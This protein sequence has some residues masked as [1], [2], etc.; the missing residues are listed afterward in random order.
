MMDAEEKALLVK[1]QEAMDHQL[2]LIKLARN[3]IK[4]Q[5]DVLEKL[6][7]RLDKLE[8]RVRIGF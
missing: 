6:M 4:L 5:Q 2:E 7:V 3:A 8:Q 1:M